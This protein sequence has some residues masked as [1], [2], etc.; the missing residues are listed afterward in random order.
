MARKQKLL[1]E[2]TGHLT[3]VQ[4]EAKYKAEILAADGLPKLQVTPPNHLKGAA[5]QEYKRIIAS[6]GK[7]PLRNL[8]R[9]EL[10]NYCTWY[11]IYKQISLD[12][13]KITAD[14]DYN[15]QKY[16]IFEKDY[17][18]AVRGNDKNLIKGLKT[19]LSLYGGKIADLEAQ[20]DNI[21]KMSLYTIFF[22]KKHRTCIKIRFHYFK[23]FL[24]FFCEYSHNRLNVSLGISNNILISKKF[25]HVTLIN[26]KVIFLQ[27][28]Y[29]LYLS[30][31]CR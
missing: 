27:Y 3:V 6:L 23:G 9:V 18:K 12:L 11:G 20:Q 24:Y 17:F 16:D 22:L 30:K 25:K 1:R 8:D 2:S 14:I 29:P 26:W 10:E 5:K 13:P 15:H 31:Y 28:L 21:L 19:S 4:Q 7:L